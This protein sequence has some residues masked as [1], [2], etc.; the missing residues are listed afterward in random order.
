MAGCWG[1]SRPV[2][3]G[4]DRGR[5][6]PWPLPVTAMIGLAVL[7]VVL[8]LRTGWRTT[9][10]AWGAST[11]L[12]L[13]LVAATPARWAEPEVWVSTLVVSSGSGLLIAILSR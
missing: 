12:T 7:L 10:V 4:S 13:V 6:G 11:V 2:V 8:G 9:A 1:A 3:V 5:V